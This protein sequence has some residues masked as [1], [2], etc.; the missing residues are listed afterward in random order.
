MDA[1][2]LNPICPFTLSNRPLVLPAKETIVI[3]IEKEQRSGVVIT[4]DGQITET[5]EPGD[6][7]LIRRAAH[8]A[9]LIA[10]EKQNF[11]RALRTK[12]AWGSEYA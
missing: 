3:E 8:D 5:L 12:L 6:R 11:Y 7:V 2:I 9:R 10:A 1:V 4:M